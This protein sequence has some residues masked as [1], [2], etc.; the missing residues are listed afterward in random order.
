LDADCIRELSRRSSSGR[1]T[2]VGG[3]GIYAEGLMFGL[4]STA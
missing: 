4:V 3:I 1:K 2:D